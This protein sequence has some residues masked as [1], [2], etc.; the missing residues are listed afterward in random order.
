MNTI[1]DM[2]VGK[3]QYICLVM[4]TSEDGFDADAFKS[5]HSAVQYF[6]NSLFPD[7]EEMLKEIRAAIE[8]A[9]IRDQHIVDINHSGMSIR[10]YTEYPLA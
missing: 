8:V 3:K 1:E 2:I 4:M 5:V 6:E 9:D 7:N 10:M